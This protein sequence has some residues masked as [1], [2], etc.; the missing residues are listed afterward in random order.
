MKV[1]IVIDD[2]GWCYGRAFT[3]KNKAIQ[4]MIKIIRANYDSYNDIEDNV[5]I[6]HIKKRNY[7]F[8]N[9]RLEELEVIE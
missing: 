7:Y 6:N 9:Y 2:E 3:N 4:H 8:L 5:L 1:Y